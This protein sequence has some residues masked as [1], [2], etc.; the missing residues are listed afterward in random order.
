MRTYCAA[1]ALLLALQFPTGAL[2]VSCPAEHARY[3]QAG[4]TGATAALVGAGRDGTAA[5]DLLL[6]VKPKSRAYRFRFQQANGYGGISLEPIYPA[7]QPL[8][9][10]GIRFIPYRADLTEIADAPR[11]GGRP[12]RVIVLP[13]FGATLWYDAAVLGGPNER[14][15]MPRSAFVLSGCDRKLRRGKASR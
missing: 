9:M 12:P 5:S 8:E 11:S 13:D 1:V 15:S 3:V 14:D 7:G 2:A 4:R 10:P 6:I